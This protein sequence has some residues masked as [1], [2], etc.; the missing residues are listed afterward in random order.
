MTANDLVEE[1]I[2]DVTN[3]HDAI[4]SSET[5]VMSIEGWDSLA[6][7]NIIFAIEAEFNL[8]IELGEIENFKKVADLL[9]YIEK[10]T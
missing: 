7:L 8:K 2:R 6:H 4:I 9:E 10:N 5:Q 1:I 3:N